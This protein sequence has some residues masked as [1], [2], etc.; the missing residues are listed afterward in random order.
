MNKKYINITLLTCIMISIIKI[1]INPD[2]LQYLYQVFYHS[3]VIV[4]FII[5]E[6]YYLSKRVDD[7]YNKSL[8]LFISLF[9]PMIVVAVFKMKIVGYVKV[10]MM[11]VILSLYFLFY[12]VL[13]NLLNKIIEESIACL[14]CI[15]LAL[16]I[17][18]LIYINALDL[19]SYFAYIV[20]SDVVLILTNLFI[21]KGRYEKG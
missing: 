13:L 21:E 15:I 12:S 3:I 19:G 14:I 17:Y 5:I 11:I 10:V 20:L 18:V 16:L 1:L 4:A 6:S 9:I 2:I 7:Y 8:L